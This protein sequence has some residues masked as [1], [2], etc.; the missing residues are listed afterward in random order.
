MSDLGR[1]TLRLLAYEG[2]LR[3]LHR[4]IIRAHFRLDLGKAAIRSGDV[5][6]P[7]ITRQSSGFVDPLGNN[8][9][10][11]ELHRVDG[12]TEASQFGDGIRVVPVANEPLNILEASAICAVLEKRG[13]CA[14]GHVAYDDFLFVTCRRGG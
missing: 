11:S 3:L 6:D 8:V 4:T 7:A 13:Q 9:S 2:I 5:I 12:P 10:Q 14:G 1:P